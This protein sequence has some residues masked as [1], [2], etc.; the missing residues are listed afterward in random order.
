MKLNLD[1]YS[2]WL[3][4]RPS[5]R[6]TEGVKPSKVKLDHCGK[7][8]LSL[9]DLGLH[10]WLQTELIIHMRTKGVVDR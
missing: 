6:I 1:H 9:P 2:V 3:K 8:V 4:I 5:S 7:T 10:P